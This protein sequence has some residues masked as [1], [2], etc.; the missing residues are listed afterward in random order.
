MS[1]ENVKD[2]ERF[3]DNHRESPQISLAYSSIN[4]EYMVEVARFV[5]K[6]VF[7][8]FL[9]LRGNGITSGGIAA[10]S[11]A[12][13]V[14]RS[15]RSLN[16]KWNSIGKDAGG[17]EALCTALKN[18]LTIVQV[19]LRNNKIDVE[20]AKFLAEMIKVNNTIKYL[21]IS[22][23]ELGLA[24]GIAIME[25]VQQNATILDCQL[26][27]SRV[28]KEVLNEIA[29]YLRRNKQNAAENALPEKTE[30]PEE[31]E[32]STEAQDQEQPTTLGATTTSGFFKTRKTVKDS[33][34]MM[35]R[36]L[37]KEREE[38]LP[39]NKLLYEQ[40]AGY[41]D[42]LLK[43]AKEEEK[44]RKIAEEQEQLATKG[45]EEREPRYIKEIRQSEEL[46]QLAYADKEVLDKELENRTRWLKMEQDELEKLLRQNEA[47]KE[48]TIVMEQSL[49]KEKREVKADV[50]K[51]EGKLL[52]AQKDFD[53]LEQE[54]KNMAINV[55]SFR[56]NVDKIIQGQ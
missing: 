39:E 51:L 34:Q 6:N 3:L 13:K 4:E 24:G 35:V 50:L 1:F 2:V 21:D 5:Q 28:G 18:N 49:I 27:G 16:L 37:A 8:K 42:K 19:D 55:E 56:V 54:C 33:N 47:I 48:E 40:L 20:G 10:L 36:L 43:D 29:Y 7:V 14:N 52:L 46:L 44:G 15:L 12:I 23:N 9:D 30:A 38:T 53:L 11:K 25:G 31:E 45:F 32:P 22:W 26:S 17:V 41:I